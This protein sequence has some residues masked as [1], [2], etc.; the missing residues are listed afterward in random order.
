MS[1]ST[2]AS[3]AGLS[4]LTGLEVRRVASVFGGVPHS[5]LL[6][7]PQLC[8]LMSQT[9]WVQSPPTSGHVADRF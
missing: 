5:V 6:A 4:Q 8:N 3:L 2:L 9:L 7:L 1:R